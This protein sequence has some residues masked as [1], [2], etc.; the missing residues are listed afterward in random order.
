MT[1][2]SLLPLLLFALL[3]SH[4]AAEERPNILFVAIDDLND[5]VG[6]LGGHPQVRTPCMDALARRGVLFT[7][8]HCPAP[9][10]GPSRAAIMSGHRTVTTGVYS[11]NA[12]YPKRLPDVESM[13][14][15]LRRHGYYVMGAGK[16]FH[17]DKN[18]PDGSFDQY[19]PPASGPIPK[20][21]LGNKL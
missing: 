2:Q 15:Y 6:C 9:V 3:G 16:L 20:E 8:A 18:Y 11:N 4:A 17:G 13:P 7:E 10:C 21:M 14:E 5:W 19:A 1:R 12:H